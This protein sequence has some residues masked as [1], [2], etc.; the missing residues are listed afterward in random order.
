MTISPEG[1]R[2][3]GCLVEKQFTTPQQY[4]LT[5]NALALACSQSTNREPVMA[6]DDQA[7]ERALA[8]LKE[9]RVVRYVLPSHGKSVIRYRQVLEETHGLDRSRLALLA[10]L[11]LRGPQTPGG[12]RSRT[13]RMTEFASVGE[14]Q[15][16]LDALARPPEPLVR[17]LARRPGQKEERW[18][19]LLAREPDGESGGPAV[20]PEADAR[21]PD[22]VEAPDPVDASEARHPAPGPP[23]LERRVEELAA[24]VAALRLRVGE[25]GDSLGALRRSLGE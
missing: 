9:L 12:L 23:D 7:A 1:G 6:M 10:V 17:L 21:R 16:E 24:E 4:P 3:L 13:G 2:V 8:E 25:L 18:Q 22:P 15:D 14:V 5:L 20:G 11:L 19:Q